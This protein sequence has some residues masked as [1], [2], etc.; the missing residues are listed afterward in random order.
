M[1]STSVSQITKLLKD[2][3]TKDYTNSDKAGTVAS[4]YGGT[5]DANGRRRDIE[6]LIRSAE[7]SGRKTEEALGLATLICELA[8]HKPETAIG[9]WN[10]ELMGQ[11]RVVTA[12]AYWGL[13]LAH[14]ELGNAVL[15]H[16]FRVRA[17]A[18]AEELSAEESD[19]YRELTQ[20]PRASAAMAIP[21]TTHNPQ[22]AVKD[23]GHW[24]HG[25]RSL[26]IGEFGNNFGEF[27]TD[28]SHFARTAEAQVRLVTAQLQQG[29]TKPA[30][31]LLQAD[32]G[33][34]KSHFVRE[35]SKKLLGVATFKTQFLERNLSAYP[36][37]DGAFQDIVLDTL[38]AL[39][40]HKPVVLFVDEVDTAIEER[41]FFQKL[42]APMNGDDFFFQGKMVS[43]SKQN[44]VVC[45]ALSAVRNALDGK[46]KWPDFLSRIPVEHQFSLPSLQSPIERV[47]RAL[48]SLVR[49]AQK[50][51]T[52]ANISK[53]SY[54]TLLFLGF[55]PWQSARELDQAVEMGLL[56]AGDPNSPLLLQ[57]V[58]LDASVVLQ[59]ETMQQVQIF[60]ADASF[61]EVRPRRL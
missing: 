47:F 18:L 17:E 16:D 38:L 35:F 59:V 41:H 45:F 24:L 25:N 9:L 54:Q 22:A 5:I 43:F 57:H 1:T 27:I 52:Y 10:S 15:A 6:K 30:A 32:P 28:D 34:G 55:N 50:L 44:L 53:V 56:R 51:T 36:S 46:P 2:I 7:L 60:G 21:G 11:Q 40:R 26:V 23:L 48:T 13:W 3:R 39:A 29:L 14:A 49:H 61:I 12:I 31:Y 4:H 42:I 37:I 33:A 19:G 8:S 20:Q 58:V